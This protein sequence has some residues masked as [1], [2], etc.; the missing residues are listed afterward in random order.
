MVE[1][2]IVGKVDSKTGKVTFKWQEELLSICKQI[3]FHN[4]TFGTGYRKIINLFKK[5]GKMP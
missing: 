1:V 4:F 3:Y 5:Y 2:P